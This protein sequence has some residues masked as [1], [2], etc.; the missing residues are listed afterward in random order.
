MS[1][2]VHDDWARTRKDWNSSNTNIPTMRLIN[3]HHLH[4]W[5]DWRIEHRNWVR[6]IRIPPPIWTDILHDE[7]RQ[8]H[9]IRS[10]MSKSHLNTNWNLSFMWLSAWYGG[11]SCSNLWNDSLFQMTTYYVISSQNTFNVLSMVK[12]LMYH[13][14]QSILYTKREK[15]RTLHRCSNV[16]SNLFVR[17]SVIRKKDNWQ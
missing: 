15:H 3:H 1:I 14:L 6:L 5:I 16:G 13:H 4:T 11:K 17:N 9:D 2:P 7:Y 10:D 8:R 12:E